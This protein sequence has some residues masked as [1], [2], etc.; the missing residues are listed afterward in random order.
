M[1]SHISVLLYSVIFCIFIFQTKIHICIN[2]RHPPPGRVVVE[3]RSCENHGV[4]EYRKPVTSYHQRWRHIERDD[5]IHFCTPVLR[6]FLY[7]YFSNKNSYMYQPTSP[8]PGLAVV[9]ETRS[10]ENHGVQEYRKSVTSHHETVTSLPRGLAVVVET[11]SY[12][13]HGVQEYR[14]SVTSHH[15]NCDVTAS[16]AR[17]GSGDK[18]LRK[19]RSTGVQ[20]I[21]DVTPRKL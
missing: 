5:V 6:D 11:R 20:K 12:E 18:K 21:G 15:G 4:Q 16:G 17:C 10:Y 2:L 1:T 13:N 8:T 7:F 14:K 9:V 19:S 3:T